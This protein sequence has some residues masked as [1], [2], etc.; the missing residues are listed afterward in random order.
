MRHMALAALSPAPGFELGRLQSSVTRLM[1]MFL[2]DDL[3][4]V[5]QGDNV[6]PVCFL[7]PLCMTWPMMKNWKSLEFSS[8]GRR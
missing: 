7:K 2:H 1:E 6:Q 4:G 8:Q 3:L 5:E